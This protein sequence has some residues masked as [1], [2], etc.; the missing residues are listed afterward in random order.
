[1]QI[2]GDWSF[3][4]KLVSAVATGL[5]M[6]VTTCS[7][8]MSG[9]FCLDKKTLSQGLRYTCQYTTFCY[10]NCV[11]LRIIAGD[12][13]NINTMGFKIG[14]ELMVKCGCKNIE[15]VG[16][17]FRDRVSRFIFCNSDFLVVTHS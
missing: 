4:R 7:D 8:P 6:G 5:A 16:I 15:E 9:F 12:R 3:Y 14:L 11:C 2:G 13:K 1:M 10:Q 17:T